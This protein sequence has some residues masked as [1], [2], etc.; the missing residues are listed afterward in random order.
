MARPPNKSGTSKIILLLGTIAAGAL[1]GGILYQALNNTDQN[2]MA[3]MGIVEDQPVVQAVIERPPVPEA[4]IPEPAP[5]EV[6]EPPPEAQEQV[7]KTQPKL[8]LLDNSDNFLRDRML[9]IKHK[10]ELQTWL[11]ADDL[12]RRSASYLDGLARGNTLS[13]I[14]PLTAPEGSFAMHSD[15]NIIW[16]NAGNYERYNATVAVLTSFDMQSLG[17]IFHFI[18]PLLETAFA[19][20]GYRPRQMDGI[21]LQSIDN[22]LATPIIVEPIELTRDS[23]AYKFADPELEAL[24]PIQKQLL[25]TG[26]ENTQRL[27]QQALLLKEALLNP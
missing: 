10:P 14:F 4:V 19:E 9:L 5:I 25:R 26:P 22:V 15:G 27:Q 12:V 8:P 20:M 24:L 13:K 1:V 21:I 7:V 17:Q 16:L 3:V 23:V 18:R 2:D 6:A 11:N